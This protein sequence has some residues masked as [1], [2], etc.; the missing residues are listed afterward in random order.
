MADI[1]DP[2]FRRE[3]R[4]NDETLRVTRKSSFTGQVHTLDLAITSEQWRVHLSGAQL[5]QDALPDLTKPERE[6]LL[7]GTTQAEWDAAFAEGDDD[8]DLGDEDEDEDEDD[9]GSTDAGR[10]GD[11]FMGDGSWQP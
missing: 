10:H 2:A 7:T 3:E 5:I 8:D 4:I 11:G 9:N 6:F 1:T